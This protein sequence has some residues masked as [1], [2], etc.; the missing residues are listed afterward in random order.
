MSA[1]TQ[2]IVQAPYRG[3][4]RLPRRPGRRA[5]LWPGLPITHHLRARDDL[6]AEHANRLWA[7][8]QVGSCGVDSWEKGVEIAG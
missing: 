6:P 8:S 4:I 5:K 2:D 7:T 1:R 3:C